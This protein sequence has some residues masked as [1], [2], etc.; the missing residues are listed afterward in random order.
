MNSDDQ[1]RDIID[2]DLY[3]EMDEEELYEL[4]QEEK[5]KALAKEQAEEAEPKRPFPK[6]AFWLIA[7]IMVVNLGAVI[8]QTFS[9]PAIDFLVTSAKLSNDAD[10][11]EYKKSIV[12]IEAGQSK[13][14]GFAITP[15]GKI[16]TNH[17]VIEGEKRISVAFPEEGL[18]QAEIEAAYPE[19]DLA[20]LDVEG[21]GL[22]YLELAT[23]TSFTEAASIY[24]IGNPLRFTGIANKGSIIGYTELDDWSQPVLM[25][26]APIYKGNSGSPVINENGKVI[27]VVF[28]TLRHD[29]HGKVGL[30]VPIDYYYQKSD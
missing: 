17:H 18:Y 22:P 24:F 12:V 4:V 25:L 10:I 29:E 14:T 2:E 23:E 19:V 6:W 16:I 5:R 21:N 13:G 9:I 7:I 28:A 26:D 20:V 3:E 27:G 11:Q 30:A 8:P 15:D 1:K